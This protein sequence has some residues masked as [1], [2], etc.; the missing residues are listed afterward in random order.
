MFK[1]PKLSQ[2]FPTQ[3]KVMF[4]GS[5]KYSVDNKNR[6]S[7]PKKI[8]ELWEKEK[9]ET[10]IIVPHTSE[11]CIVVYPDKIYI[12]ILNFLNGL[13][14][15]DSEA[16]YLKRR[17]LEDVTAEKMDGQYRI[18]IPSEY[19]NRANINNEVIILGQISYFEVWNPEEYEKYKSS[20]ELP[21]EEYMKKYLNAGPSFPHLSSGK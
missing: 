1:F 9:F 13:N 3:G 18:R 5:F 11:K 15:F 21:L 16:A 19:L 2:K 20:F 12:E 10:F 4:T 6:I 17:M 8:R 7:I 14:P